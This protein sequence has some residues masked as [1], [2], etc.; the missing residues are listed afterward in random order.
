MKIQEYNTG[1][2]KYFQRRNQMRKNPFLFLALLGIA[3]LALLFACPAVNGTSAT[4]TPTATV[5]PAPSTGPFENFED[6]VFVSGSDLTAVNGTYRVSAVIDPGTGLPE[7]INGQRVY[8]HET[9]AD[10]YICYRGCSGTGW[11]LQDES[12]SCAINRSHIGTDFP[13]SGTWQT[14]NV[15]NANSPASGLIEVTSLGLSG[16]CVNGQTLSA[17]HTSRTDASYAWYRCTD[18]VGTADTEIAGATSAEYALTVADIGYYIRYEAA[19]GTDPSITDITRMAIID[20]PA[21]STISV[22][23]AADNDGM[24]NPVPGS[25]YFDVNGT[26]TQI[27]YFNSLPLYQNTTT[28]VYLCAYGCGDGW[29]HFMENYGC[30]QNSYYLIETQSPNALGTAVSYPIACAAPVSNLVSPTLVL[31]P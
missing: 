23:G 26:Y 10:Y 16:N 30:T 14:A 5:T 11:V 7:E 21:F 24:G 25:P 22:S 27:G 13:G 3:S 31:N 9:N 6:V 1:Y 29:Y 19:L 12:T 20:V 15:N 28:G 8:R 18:M 2:A 4:P 17:P